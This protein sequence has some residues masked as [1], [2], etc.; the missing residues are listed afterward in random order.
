MQ[1]IILILLSIILIVHFAIVYPYCNNPFVKPYWFTSH[2]PPFYSNPFTRFKTILGCV[3]CITKLIN[4]MSIYHCLKA[5][6]HWLLRN[7]AKI[8]I[9]HKNYEALCDH[10][11]WY[12]YHR[13]DTSSLIKQFRQ[14]VYS[15]CNFTFKCFQSCTR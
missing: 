9:N 15:Q 3:H 12:R 6:T 14:Y 7:Y 2:F 4:I 8:K 1:S 11:I 13:P 5:L 10:Y